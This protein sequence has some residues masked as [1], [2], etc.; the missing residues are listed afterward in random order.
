MTEINRPFQSIVLA[1]AIGLGFTVVW[2]LFSIWAVSTAAPFF[3]EQ[4]H[5]VDGTR[6]GLGFE[7]DGT[8][9]IQT[10]TT[11][12]ENGYGQSEEGRSDRKTYTDES[13]YPVKNWEGGDLL[14][15]AWL[16]AVDKS[17][18]WNVDW[19]RRILSFLD[20]QHS[21]DFWYFVHDGEKDGDGYF[22]GYQSHSNELL[23][24]IGK[25][26]FSLEKPPEAEHF[27]VIP[28]GWDFIRRFATTQWDFFSPH[29][30]DMDRYRGSDMMGFEHR[31]Y[32]LSGN[33]V[34][35]VDFRDQSVKEVY[36]SAA[37]PILSIGLLTRYEEPK[38]K[39]PV[40]R[41]ESR[42]AAFDREG[43]LE[44]E[45]IL[46]EELRREKGI[47]FISFYRTEHGTVFATTHTSTT[48]DNLRHSFSRVWRFDKDGSVIST[49]DIRLG[50]FKRGVDE[51][52]AAI[53]PIVG[54]LVSESTLLVLAPAF[55]WLE[56]KGNTVG[57]ALAEAWQQLG[58]PAVELALIHIL[59]AL[60][61]WTCYRRQ[62]SYGQPK[63]QVR[64]WT[65]FVFCFGLPGYVGY[66]T[67]RQ[68]PA[69]ETC[70]S[71]SKRVPVDREDCASCGASFP[72]PERNGTEVFA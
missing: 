4:G 11:G 46:P 20:M 69:L 1:A 40:I 19:S 58:E 21:P 43:N 3:F 37:E 35:L 62:V 53:V 45:G 61:A 38:E 9:V 28:S 16:P 67:H 48:E 63:G 12:S 31:V 68:W 44:A 56:G 24:Y 22:V 70:P 26:G 59:G 15:G 54:P 64:L 6:I 7:L 17:S 66:L 25:S 29:Y 57:E 33:T 41:M 13:G 49:Q 51:D 23:G 39:T 65:A 36:E 10:Q 30:P 55:A 71:C 27:P 47:S 2:F 50:T 5:Y 32:L 42:V 34:Y 72:A 52:V 18:A 60:F 14:D 8:P